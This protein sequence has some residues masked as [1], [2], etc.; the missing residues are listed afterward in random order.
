M[1]FDEFLSA[2]SANRALAMPSE[3]PPTRLIRPKHAA[4]FLLETPTLRLPRQQHPRRLRK[5]VH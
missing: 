3:M 2:S 1:H 5:Q 4:T